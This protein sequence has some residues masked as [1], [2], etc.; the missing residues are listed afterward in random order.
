MDG[1]KQYLVDIKNAY[2]F[3]DILTLLLGYVYSR[4]ALGMLVPRVSRG[5]TL[6]RLST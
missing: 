2:I 3:I 6:L 5:E 1:I 4:H